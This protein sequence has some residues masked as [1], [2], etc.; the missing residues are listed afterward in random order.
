MLGKCF[1]IRVEEHQCEDGGVIKNSTAVYLL[2]DIIILG[3]QQKDLCD[4]I[5]FMA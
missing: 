5:C 2:V 4:P 3:R 1:N